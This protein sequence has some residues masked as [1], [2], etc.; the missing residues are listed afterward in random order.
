[1]K[2]IIVLLTLAVAS[3]A[4]HASPTL[5]GIRRCAQVE[6]LA[7]SI[8]TARQSGVPMGSL[9]SIAANEDNVPVRN[10]IVLLIN[11][12]YATDIVSEKAAEILATEFGNRAGLMC[13]E[14]L[15]NDRSGVL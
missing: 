6:T 2:K 7:N 14:S 12:A 8:M 9:L 15:K 10:L 3:I 1:M 5:E 13:L 4:A 11:R